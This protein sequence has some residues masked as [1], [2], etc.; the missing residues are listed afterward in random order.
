MN[1]PYLTAAEAA[2]EL[3]VSRATLYAYVSRG[4]VRAVSVQGRRSKLYAAEDVRHLRGRKTVDTASSERSEPL[5][6]GAPVMDS[7]LT[8]IADGR[9]YYRGR[10]VAGLA[11]TASLESVAGLLW[12]VEADPFAA[13]PPP[14]PAHLPPAYG[15]EGLERCLAALPLAAAHDLGAFHLGRASV[16]A[17]G[18]RILRLVAAIFCD[19][20]PAA[21]PVHEQFAAAWGL[22]EDGATVIRAALV[23]CAD[24]ELNASAFTV[25]CVA[26]TRA[27]PYNAVIAGLAAI[28][29][30]RHGGLSVRVPALF[31]EAAEAG[32]AVAAV[33]ERLRR[34]EMLPGFGHKLYPDGDPR[35]ALLLEV[36]AERGGNGVACNACAD[37]AEAVARLTGLRPNVDFALAAAERVLG[38]PAKASLALFATARTAGWIAHALEQYRRPEMIRPR[39]R[40][41]GE[42]PQ[43]AR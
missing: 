29:G 39:A 20:E 19:R 1:K 17:T 15:I 3:N 4:L 41:T 9:F 35:A 11:A 25:R 27:S 10:D 40:Y 21:A 2:A 26:A 32:D 23:L 33:G 7:A 34:G 5:Q 30:P 18:A 38:L 31:D 8:L 36:L 28:Q 12:N 14:L 16:A 13:P 37:V 6:F 43:P 42:E 24:H 22:N